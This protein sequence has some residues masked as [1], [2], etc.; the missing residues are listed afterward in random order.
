MKQKTNEPIKKIA[1]MDKFQN[2]TGRKYIIEWS[3]HNGSTYSYEG[4]LSGV[5][6]WGVPTLEFDNGKCLINAHKFLSMIEYKTKRK[7]IK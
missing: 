1:G 6:H 4:V 5:Y 2:L 7:V 3:H